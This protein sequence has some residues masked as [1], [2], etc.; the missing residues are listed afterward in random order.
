MLEQFSEGTV[1]TSLSN[2]IIEAFLNHD[3][4]GR[5][6]IIS[7]SRLQFLIIVIGPHQPK[8]IRYSINPTIINVNRHVPRCTYILHYSV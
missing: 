1:L 4:G 2:N 3:P 6:P 5:R 7:I 8:L